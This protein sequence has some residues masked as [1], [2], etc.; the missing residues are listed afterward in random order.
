MFAC[1][2]ALNVQREQLSRQVTLALF[3]RVRARPLAAGRGKEAGPAELYLALLSRLYSPF[4]NL[5][6]ARRFAGPLPYTFD[7]EPETNSIV[8]IKATRTRWEPAVEPLAEFLFDDSDGA[9][10]ST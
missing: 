8:M 7:Y 4:A 3:D 5:E 2:V 1:D 10:R 9:R 6:D